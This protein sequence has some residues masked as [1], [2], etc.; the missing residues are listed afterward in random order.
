MRS[1][2]DPRKSAIS[3]SWKAFRSET[4]K[5]RS[6]SQNFWVRSCSGRWRLWGWSVIIQWLK[7]TD[8]LRLPEIT[9]SIAMEKLET[10]SHL[11]WLQPTGRICLTRSAWLVDWFEDRQIFLKVHWF[12]KM[13]LPCLK[14]LNCLKF[15]MHF[16]FLEFHLSTSNFEF[17]AS[18]FEPIEAILVVDWTLVN[19]VHWTIFEI[20]K[21]KSWKR[22]LNLEISTLSSGLFSVVFFCDY[23]LWLFSLTLFSGCPLCGSLCLKLASG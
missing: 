14:S 2:Y 19:I 18:K 12:S 8:F 1:Y 3:R 17:R 6:F 10:G 9:F 23:S 15:R 4:C 16:T 5:R 20:C 11:H 22:A 7:A 21:M 13:I